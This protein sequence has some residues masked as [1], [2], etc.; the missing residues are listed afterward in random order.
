MCESVSEK[1]VWRNESKGW[2]PLSGEAHHPPNP[3]S[4]GMDGASGSI[5]VGTRKMVIYA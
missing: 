4:P 3:T 1:L 5:Y 2:D